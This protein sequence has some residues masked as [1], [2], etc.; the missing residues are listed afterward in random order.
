MALDAKQRQQ[1]LGFAI[2]VA[3]VAVVAFWMYWRAPKVAEMAGMR[4][5]ID[6]L[7][8]RV[9]S[10]RRDL[11]SG[12][13]EALRRRVRDFEA[14][15]GV[16]RTL[17]PTGAEVP[18]LIDDVSARAKR[19]GVEIAEITP[20][21]PD[22]GRPFETHRYRFSVIGHYDEIGEFLADVAS[23][24][25]IMVPLEVAVTRASQTAANTYRD[26]TGALAQATFQLRT[27]VKPGAADTVGGGQQ[28]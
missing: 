9:D 13:V 6:S 24:R 12:T 7:Q 5:R 22:P 2:F 28:R 1:L 23:L 4:I 18:S 21:S 8:A 25:R 10:A 16:M 15:L 19:R 26:T 17:V 20:M 3:V 14:S 11:A 27:F